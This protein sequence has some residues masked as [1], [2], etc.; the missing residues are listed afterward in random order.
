MRHIALAA[1]LLAGTASVAAAGGIDRASTD[2]SLLWES[3]DRIKLSFG[4]VTPDISG[5]YSAAFGA[6]AGTSTGDMAESFTSLGF[7]YKNQ[8]NDRWA[9]ALLIDQPYGAD[10]SYSQGPYTGLNATWNSES[11]TLLGHYRFNERFSV[12]GGPRLVRSDAIV[13]IPGTLLAG[14]TY[15]GVVSN[16]NEIGAVVGAAYEIPEIALRVAL[17]YQSEVEHNF[18]SNEA[19]LGTTTAL[20]ANTAITLPQAVTLDFQ[21]GIAADTLVFGSLR[22]SEWSVY[23]I[24]PPLFLGATGQSVATIR[25]DIWAFN[26]GVGRRLNENLSVFARFGYEDR[27]GS[28]V[29]RLAP[30]DGRRSIGVGG[31]YTM[32]N[33]TWTGALEYIDIGDARDGAGTQFSDGDALAAGLS[34]S[35]G[36]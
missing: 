2:T 28:V 29:S 36:F 3:G 35:F 15:Q 9:I 33:A 23:D 1:A 20:T 12:Y 11:V 25:D 13:Q 4:Y 26:I 24:R 30:T 34:V 6:F 14:A 19:F 21:S 7:G 31:S 27:N 5:T 8:L 10:A 17:T 16:D 32:G 18:T 22:W